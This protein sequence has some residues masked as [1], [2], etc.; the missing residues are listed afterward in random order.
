MIVAQVTQSCVMFEYHICNVLSQVH[1]PALYEY[2]PRQVRQ[3]VFESP[4]QVAQG[5]AQST[6]LV[7]L[8]IIPVLQIEQVVVPEVVQVVQFGKIV[9]HKAQLL[10]FSVRYIPAVALQ[11]HCIVP[12]TTLTINGDWQTIHD[13][14]STHRRHIPG[15]M[16]ALHVEPER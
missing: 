14:P 10:P 3:L 2:C 11:T 12:L 7:P 1:C 13:V 16:Q 4:L 9:E 8:K 15:L 5:K 6:Q